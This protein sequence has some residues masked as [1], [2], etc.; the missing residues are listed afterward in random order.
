[1]SGARKAIDL[2][3]KALRETGHAMDRLTLT[4]AENE[5]FRETFARHRQM[6]PLKQKAPTV[7]KNT[8]VAPNAA[9]IGSVNLMEGSNVRFS[10]H[11]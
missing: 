10:P 7:G 1:M 3:G 4:A 2:F 5:L 8:F 11:D 6:M 9:V